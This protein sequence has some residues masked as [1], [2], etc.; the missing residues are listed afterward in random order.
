[1]RAAASAP[2]GQTELVR[3]TNVFFKGWL[4]ILETEELKE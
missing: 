3:D 1:V 4:A 2:G